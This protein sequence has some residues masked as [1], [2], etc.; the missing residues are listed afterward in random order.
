MAALDANARVSLAGDAPPWAQRFAADMSAKAARDAANPT[1][2]PKFAASNKPPAE[3]W[4]GAIITNL[5]TGH[6]EFSDGTNWIDPV[7][8]APDLSGY[9]PI[10]RTISAGAG[11]SGGGD[12]SANR[13]LAINY[14]QTPTWTG[15]HTFNANLAINLGAAATPSIYFAGDVNTGIWSPAADT[16]AFSTAGVSRL[17]ISSGGLVGV[18]MTPAK[19]F[20]VQGLVA[21]DYAARINPHA[22][23]GFGLN[24]TGIGTGVAIAASSVS[25]FAGDFR[26]SSTHAFYARNTSSGGYS[27][28]GDAP[29]SNSYGGMI[30]YSNNGSNYGIIGYQ[31]WGGYFNGPVFASSYSTSDS[32]FK[33]NVADIGDALPMIEALRAVGF[34]WKERTEQRANG[35][36]RS[37]GFIA[38]EALEILPPECVRTINAPDPRLDPEAPED[39]EALT[40]QRE[41]GEFL[42]MDN[43]IV[44]PF[45]V[46]AVQQLAERVRALEAAR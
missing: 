37:Y 32:R 41:I 30:G 29:G 34:D 7:D 9:V 27:I 22:T 39:L 13:S 26:A 45:L 11:L 19:T 17:R 44:I 31:T 10:A 38:Q 20:D 24:A 42:V 28:F 3:S 46:R 15:L 12:L 25:G 18:G 23:N 35:F 43:S 5:D 40:L 21:A 8:G 6:I 16:I 4:A 1:R 14:A 2:T 33:E 36:V